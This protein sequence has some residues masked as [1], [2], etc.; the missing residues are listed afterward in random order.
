MRNVIVNLTVA[1]SHL[2]D[3]TTEEIWSRWHPS[4]FN[5]KSNIGM[6][7]PALEKLTLNFSYLELGPKDVIRVSPLWCLSS[8]FYLSLRLYTSLDL[9]VLMSFLDATIH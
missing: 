6:G 2:E 4:V 5:E 1:G 3:V 8:N 7:F 9:N